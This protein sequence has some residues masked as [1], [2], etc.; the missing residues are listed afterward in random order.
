MATKTA[1]KKTTATKKAAGKATSKK[2]CGCKK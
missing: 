2:C 1:P